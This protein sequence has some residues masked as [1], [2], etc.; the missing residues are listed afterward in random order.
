MPIAITRDVSPTLADCQLTHVARSPID[1]ERAQTQHRAYQRALAS[2]G[3]RVLALE[4]EPDMPDAVFVED[5]AVVLDDVAI[6]TRP[7]AASRRAEGA[8]VAE[9]LARYRPLRS[10]EAPGTLDGGDVLRVGHT[11]FVGQS[12]RSNADGIAQL[13]K[14]AG[15]SG[16][17]VRAVPIRGCL[18]L[19]SAV[20]AVRDDTLLLQPAWVDAASFPGFTVIEVDPSEEHAA[21]I[22]RIGDSV[23]MP[24]G[25]PRTHQRLVD[26]GIDV[27]TVDVSELQKAE[28]A[29]TCCSLV[30][31][32]AAA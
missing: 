9:L 4:A 23:V 22:L 29:T 13:A 30:F 14:L 32:E 10:I 7:G 27:V 2:L 16:Y 19:K 6:M 18:H 26:A 3:C 8:S 12:G 17:A 28:G 31:A 11:L 25:F 5:V 20:T 1:I 21:N 24:A 15:Q